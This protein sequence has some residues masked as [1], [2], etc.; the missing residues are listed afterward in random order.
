VVLLTQMAKDLQL[1]ASFK[2]DLQEKWRILVL[3]K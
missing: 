3:K 2:K 1:K